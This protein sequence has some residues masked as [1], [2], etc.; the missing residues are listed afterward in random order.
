MKWILK[1]ETH[2]WPAEKRC[3]AVNWSPDHIYLSQR[4]CWEEIFWCE[5]WRYTLNMK[6][7][8]PWALQ[9]LFCSDSLIFLCHPNPLHMETYGNMCV[10]NI[11]SK[12]WHNYLKVSRYYVEGSIWYFLHT[13]PQEASIPSVLK[14][15][16]SVHFISIYLDMLILCNHIH[17]TFDS[18]TH[19]K[20]YI[21][22]TSMPMLVKTLLHWLI[23]NHLL[24]SML[25][26]LFVISSHICQNTFV[27]WIC[28][29]VTHIIGQ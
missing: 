26:Y 28:I 5:G 20:M 6:S 23:L 16:D 2:T 11:M 29:F 8:D 1:T 12:G 27:S 10:K 24:L 18:V 14:C 13:C 3:H 15:G 22:A 7:D 9:F 21:R 19:G 25:S 17:K 4:S